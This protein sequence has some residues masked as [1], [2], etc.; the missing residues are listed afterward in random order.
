V[1]NYV[2]HKKNNETV[3]AY[4]KV[5]TLTRWISFGNYLYVKSLKTTVL[6]FRPPWGAF[7]QHTMFIFGSLESA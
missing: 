1:K 3:L 6:R 4:T 7:A 2:Y 5:V